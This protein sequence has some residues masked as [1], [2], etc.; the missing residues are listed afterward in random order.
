MTGLEFYLG[1]VFGFIGGFVVAWITV[2][3]CCQAIKDSRNCKL[4]TRQLEQIEAA[5]PKEPCQ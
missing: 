3:L 2:A 4:I 1:I 5:Y